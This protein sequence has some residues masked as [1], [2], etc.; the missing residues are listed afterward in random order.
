ML[1]PPSALPRTP[2]QPKATGTDSELSLKNAV[3]TTDD[4]STSPQS[5]FADALAVREG[6]NNA[7]V[8]SVNNDV[9]A[10]NPEFRA[11][12]E[13][14]RTRMRDEFGHDV[15][16]VEGFR[17]QARQNFLY[18]QGRT[19]PGNVVTW[20]KSSKHTAGL[21]VD[22]I[23]DGTY[24]NPVAYQH[25]AQIAAQEGL[26]TLGP[27]DPGH[28]ELPSRNG[29][30]AWG[31]SVTDLSDDKH[32]TRAVDLAFAKSLPITN[33]Q[34]PGQHSDSG[35]FNAFLS[36][37]QRT[38]AEAMM[39]ARAAQAHAPS[40]EQRHADPKSA[41]VAQVAQIADVA[42]VANVASVA[43]AGAPMH[44]T[45]T[46]LPMGGTPS[47]TP[48]AHGTDAVARIGHL[49]DVRDASPAPPLSHITLTL[50]NDAGGTDHVRVDVRGTTV[51]TRITLDNQVHADRMSLRVGELQRA[52]E[53]RGLDA[54]SV[55]IGTAGQLAT[56]GPS[57][58]TDSG[59]GWTPRQQTSDNRDS[60]RQDAGGPHHRS[61]RDKERK[62]K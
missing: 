17:P 26:R 22:L 19:R 47:S 41:A 56:R 20:T 4:A 58:Q 45:R 51:D 9:T 33:Q 8:T 32:V 43:A 16:I 57:A 15:D 48:A 44:A 42:Q 23:I 1:V 27:R 37:S 38:D 50:D 21:A 7:P 35:S 25:L 31:E 14:V 10:L 6:A 55:Q 60:L 62:H 34:Q 39:V 2:A 13:R 29:S 11:R 54:E 12:L 49:L 53:H 40:A 3:R 24:N 28:V 36:R 46:S 59:S 5:A 52:L 18:E 30:E 61:Q